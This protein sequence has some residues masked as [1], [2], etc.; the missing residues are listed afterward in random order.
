M[1]PAS[2]RILVVEDNPINQRLATLQLE[3]LGYVS[4]IV[5]TGL[6]AITAATQGDYQLV[7]MDCQMPD[8]DG[9]EATRTIRHLEIETGQHIP[10]VALTP[11]A[12]E[13]DRR[14]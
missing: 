14:P 6:E 7:I 10:I 12:T 8:L 5:A 9:F 2:Q 4:D 13:T 1:T 3:R 11:N